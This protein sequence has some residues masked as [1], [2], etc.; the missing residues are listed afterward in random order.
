MKN[1]VRASFGLIMLDV[2]KF[3]RDIDLCVDCFVKRYP[4]KADKMQKVKALITNPTGE[5]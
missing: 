2:G 3:S 4:R 5:G 1:I